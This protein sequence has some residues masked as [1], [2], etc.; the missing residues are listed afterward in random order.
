MP[1]IKHTAESLS[2][3]KLGMLSVIKEAPAGKDWRGNRE[4]RMRCQCD[5]GRLVIVSVPSLVSGNTQSCGCTHRENKH[6]LKHGLS[7]S[8]EFE[9]WSGIKKRCNNPKAEC[10]RNYG[11]RGITVCERWDKSFQSFLE[12]VGLRPSSRHSLDRIDNNRGYEPANVR[13]A[14]RKQQANNMRV[15]R[16]IT[17]LGITRTMAEWADC[18]GINYRTIAS[19]IAMGWSQKDAVTKIPDWRFRS[20][21]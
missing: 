11:G 8:S 13:W 12:D 2:V 7:T 15:N 18:T 21:K 20:K 14:T 19:R 17:A 9:I 10:Y 16:N 3:R 5:C 4:R 6:S 1:P